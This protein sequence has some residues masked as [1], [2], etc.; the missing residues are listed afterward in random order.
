MVGS[1]AGVA[2]ITGAPVFV[3]FGVSIFG[4]TYLYYSRFLEV[5]EED[6]NEQ[7]IMMEGVGNS[8]GLFLLSWIL[9]YSYA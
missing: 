8:V 4:L 1:V 6:F 2:K 7:E 3:A 9:L 5:D